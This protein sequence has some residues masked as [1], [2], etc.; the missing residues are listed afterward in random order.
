MKRSTLYFYVL[1]LLVAM[2]LSGR[3]VQAV[4]ISEYLTPTENSSPA[5]LAFD[6]EGNLWFTEINA[7]KIGKL[8]PSQTEPGT[9]KGIV[10]YDLPHPHSQ[11]NHILVARNGMVWFSEMGGNRIGRLDPA[12][13]KITEYEI[14]TAKSEPHHLAEAADGAIWFVEF[15][16]NKI[17]RLDPG[18]GTIQEFPVNEGH[19]HDLV[20]QGDR[21][22]Y[23]QGG[24]FWARI[25]FN[26]MASFDMNTHE[27]REITIPPKNSVP[28][29]VTLDAKGSVWF[30]QFFAH[31]ISRLEGSQ[32]GSPRIVD[33]PVPGKRKGPH[34]IVVDDKNGWVWFVLNHADSIGRLDLARAKPGTS[35]GMEE[36]K[37]PTSGGNPNSLTLDSEG[38]VWFVEMGKYF[39]GK[40]QNKIGKLI[41]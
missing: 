18:A 29:G 36:F 14:P 33:Y 30:T 21:I 25:F 17:A 8:I 12:T 35:E 34:D 20:I 38:N 19:P 7:D 39:R 37:I 27:V 15:E 32:Q 10:E 23:S 9:S 1:F 13:G 31:K 41:P 2:T 3:P 26:K 11:P 28:H 16:T 22:W 5:G 4:T 24:K 40:Y 6:A